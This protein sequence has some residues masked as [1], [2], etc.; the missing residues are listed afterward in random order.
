MRFAAYSKCGDVTAT[1]VPAEPALI[2]TWPVKV[3][4]RLAERASRHLRDHYPGAR[5]AARR[6]SRDGNELPPDTTR[7]AKR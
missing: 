6:R 1:T 4:G 3:I 2:R 5:V 7:T